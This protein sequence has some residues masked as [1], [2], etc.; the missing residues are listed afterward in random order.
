MKEDEEAG[1]DEFLAGL[2]F[3]VSGEFESIS[4]PKLEEY[5]KEHGG[6]LTSA[7]SGKTNYLIVGYKLEDGR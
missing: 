4:R 5:I 2:T 6:R 7:V 3:V 1:E